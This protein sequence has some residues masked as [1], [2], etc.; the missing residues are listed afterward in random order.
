MDLRIRGVDRGNPVYEVS[1]H[2]T[3]YP[4]LLRHLFSL[5]LRKVRCQGN[6]KSPQRLLI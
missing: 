1:H 3:L 5:T 2:H 6:Y 4:H